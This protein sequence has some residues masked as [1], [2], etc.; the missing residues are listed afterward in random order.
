MP[1]INGESFPDYNYQEYPKWV[2]LPNGSSVIVETAHE[3]H[4]LLGTAPAAEEEEPEF[5]GFREETPL[6][7]EVPAD[8]EETTAE[9]ETPIVAPDGEVI[10]EDLETLREQADTMGLIYD[11]RWGEIKLRQ[12]IDSAR[13]HGALSAE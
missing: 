11:K 3:E 8:I 10:E 12:A 1:T 6:V 13:A 2:T 4:M 7:V 9:E 5:V